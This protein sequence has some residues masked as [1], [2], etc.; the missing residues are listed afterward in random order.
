MKVLDLSYHPSD[1][2]SGRWLDLSRK[3]NH[4]TSHG[5]ARP[6]QIAPGV[7]GFEFDGSSGY[8]DCGNSK[9]LAITSDI[10]IGAW[11]Y[12][13]SVGS[14][15][16]NIVAKSF[17]NSY[18]FRV[19]ADS[20]KLWLLINDGTIATAEGQNAVPVKAWSYVVAKFV[21]S[22][23][24]VY[25]YINNILDNQVSNGKSSIK[26][27]ESGL[28]VGVN[29]PGGI[30]V[31]DGLIAQLIIE[32]RA[33][34]EAEVRENMYRSPVYRMLRGLPHSQVY[35]TVPWKQTQ[36]GIYVL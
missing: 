19:Q 2:R 11:I 1:V 22:E 6:F 33:W 15:H 17:N 20:R 31:F 14:T 3:G 24:N 8:V 29:T 23:Q 16:R 12:P 27:D 34:S 26:A 36:G 10:T 4:G 30:E 13:R 32:G 9:S 35:I 7:M 25:F 18:R 28:T 5:G 21:A